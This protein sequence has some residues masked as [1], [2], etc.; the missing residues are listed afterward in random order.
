MLDFLREPFNVRNS[1]K[2]LGNEQKYLRQVLRAESW[3]SLSGSWVSRAED[4]TRKLLGSRYAIAMNSGTSTLHSILEAYRFP[5]GSEVL[6][7]ALTVIMDATICYLSNLK[8]VFVDIDPDTFLMSPCDLE[9]KI[10]PKSVA[11]ITV[12]LYGNIPDMNTIK[13]IC[14]KKSLV[15]IEDNAQ[16]LIA[17]DGTNSVGAWGI[18]SSWSFENTK[19]ISSGEGG[20]VTTNCESLAERVRKVAGHGFKNLR[21]EEGRVRLVDDV[22]QDPSYERHDLLGWNYRMSE[23]TAAVALAQLERAHQLVANRRYNAELLLSAIGTSEVLIPQLISEGNTCDYYTFACLYNYS[24]TKSVSWQDFR[25]KFKEKTGQGIYSA[26][27]V[28]YQEPM[29]S[30][31]SYAYRYPTI[32]QDCPCYEGS[33]PVA[34]RIQPQ[35]MQ[36]KTNNRNPRLARK[37]AAQLHDLIQEVS[38]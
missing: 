26:W 3:S 16:S 21:A 17:S 11:V 5:P 38:L 36:F 30:S 27:K 2:Y 35:L 8:P 12:S 24:A 33:C 14:D 31:Q 13:A 15:L 7:P 25:R 32:Y 6:I 22:F 4:E 23:I 1:S 34:E 20:A 37:I 19:H 28:V 10:T 18:A 29:V 9:R